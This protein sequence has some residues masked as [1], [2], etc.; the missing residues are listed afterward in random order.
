M[1]HPPTDEELMA[2]ADGALDAKRNQEIAALVRKDKVLA[3][4]VEMFRQSAM[5]VKRAAGPLADEPVPDA[6]RKSIEAKISASRPE[7]PNVVPFRAK[8][9]VQ[10]VQRPWALPLAASIAAVVA[11]VAGYSLRDGDTSG[12][13]Q[14][15]AVG[16]PLPSAFAEK[17]A[18]AASGEE[19]QLNGGRLRIVTSVFDR[20]KALC[21][22]F[23]YDLPAADT[24]I[25]VACRT[26]ASSW[27]TKLAIAAPAS[28]TGYAPASSTTAADAYFDA[29]GAS[30]PLSPADEKAA[31]ESLR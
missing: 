17:L 10:K 31:L 15:I 3:R 30:E 24:V 14:Q 27:L 25:A 8:P 9:S 1:T 18:A 5:L 26:P 4:R 29:I 6:L 28:E 12:P 16:Q 22:E 23:E 21:R 19:A 13:L 20:D 11:G 7:S 2:H